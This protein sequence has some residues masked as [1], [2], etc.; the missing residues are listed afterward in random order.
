M[1]HSLIKKFLKKTGYKAIKVD[2]FERHYIKR[3]YGNARDKEINTR[4]FATLNELFHIYLKDNFTFIQIGANNGRRDDPIH[5]LL[6]EHHEH[7]N[8]IA[9]EPIKENFLELQQT[10]QDY[11]NIKLLQCAIHNSEVEMPI[12]KINSEL[13]DI[14]DYL[15]GMASFD[16]NN[17]TKDGIPDE[18]ILTDTVPCIS[19]MNLIDREEIKKIHLLQI[20]AEGYDLEIIKSID[21]NKIKPLIINFEHR[22]KDRHISDD[23]MLLVLR[24]LLENDYKIIIDG[25]DALAYL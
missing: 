24:Q 4:T 11:P 19:L 5:H 14:N 13:T 7:I 6:V 21:F 15:R 2:F 22:W 17:F 1:I 12:Y 16:K 9:I 18:Q 8:G 25:Y 23:A 3:F 10:Y 20:D